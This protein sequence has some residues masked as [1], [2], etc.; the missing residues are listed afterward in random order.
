MRPRLALPAVAACLAL[1]AGT[2]S[3]LV[4]SQVREGPERGSWEPQDRWAATG[5]RVYATALGAL[6]LQADRRGPR[7]AS[8]TGNG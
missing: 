4:A 8:W 2:S 5:G 3:A 6:I 1:A 7:L